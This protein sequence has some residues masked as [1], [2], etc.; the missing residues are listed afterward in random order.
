MADMA[1]ATYISEAESNDS[2]LVA[3]NLDGHFSLDSVS[4][5]FWSTSY[6]H[7]S[8]N[9]TNSATTDVDYYKFTVG[10]GGDTGFFDIDYGYDYN[11]I[12]VDTIMALFDSNQNVLAVSDDMNVPI[13]PGSNSS[14]D[15]FIGE[16]TFTNPGS[17]YL[18]VSNLQNCPLSSPDLSLPTPWGTYLGMGLIRPD[19]VQCNAWVFAGDSG[20]LVMDT[21]SRQLRIGR[22]RPACV[23]V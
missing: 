18:A 13:D 12:D 5:I 6:W 23:S 8:V 10:S 15:S 22:L 20:A 2:F 9:A 1:S 16:Y 21:T 4:D 14:L 17:Y 3:Q 7:A 19:L 11:G